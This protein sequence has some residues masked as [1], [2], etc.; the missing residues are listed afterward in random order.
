MDNEYGKSKLEA[1]SILNR[2]Q[3]ENGNP[4]LFSF[5]KRIWKMVST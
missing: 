4:V 3:S 2:L 5:T 1:E